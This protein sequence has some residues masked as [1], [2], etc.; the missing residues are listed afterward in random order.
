MNVIQD[1]PCKIAVL[2]WFSHDGIAR[3]ICEELVNLGHHPVC[4]IYGAPI[5]SSVDVVLTHGPYGKLLPVWQQAAQLSSG[6]R[7]SVV[8]WNTEGYPDLRLPPLVMWTLSA[9]RSRLGR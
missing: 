4:F 7:S 9:Y 5:P 1:I 2:Q 3:M 8:H 6:K